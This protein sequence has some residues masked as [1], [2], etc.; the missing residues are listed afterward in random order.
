MSI[1]VDKTR[2]AV[3]ALGG[4]AVALGS[5]DA[6][7]KIK[8]TKKTVDNSGKLPSWLGMSM[9]LIG[10]VLFVSSF[11]FEGG[12]FNYHAMDTSAIVATLSAVVGMVIVLFSWW[13]HEQTMA[14]IGYGWVLISVIALAVMLTLVPTTG[15]GGYRIHPDAFFFVAFGVLCLVAGYSIMTSMAE[16]RFDGEKT[17]SAYR[18]LAIPLVTA[19]WLTLAFTSSMMQFYRVPTIQ[20]VSIP[21]TLSV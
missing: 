9:F 7:R 6:F 16:Q 5:S 4:L 3:A 15:F 13:N 2:L 21:G 8:K 20:N 19:G 17:P 10:T 11:G 1:V 12:R 18:P 14:Q